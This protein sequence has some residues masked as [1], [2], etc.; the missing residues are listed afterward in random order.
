VIIVAVVLSK[1]KKEEKT[2]TVQGGTQYD[3]AELKA[4]LAAQSKKLDELIEIT[5]GGFND[6]VD[7]E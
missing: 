3:D 7:G 1:R 4:Q 6:F 2:V 5:D